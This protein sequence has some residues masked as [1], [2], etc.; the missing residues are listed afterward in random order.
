M[1][2]TLRRSEMAAQ[3]QPAT[4]KKAANYGPGKETAHCGSCVNFLP[5]SDPFAVGKCKKVIGGIIWH[6]WCELFKR[7]AH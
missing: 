2:A 6:Q 1:A 7:G 4:S 3:E 5:D